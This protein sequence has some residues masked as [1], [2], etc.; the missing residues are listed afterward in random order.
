[1]TAAICYNL[2][3]AGNLAITAFAD[4]I[5]NGSASIEPTEFFCTEAGFEQLFPVTL[6]TGSDPGCYGSPGGIFA[7]PLSEMGTVFK[8]TI[9][10]VETT[11]RSTSP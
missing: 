11:W 1:M 10:G 9:G 8:V 3:W 2:T 4:F 7:G 6:G 5:D